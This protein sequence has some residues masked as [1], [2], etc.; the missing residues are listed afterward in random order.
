MIAGSMTV[1]GRDRF[2]VGDPVL[3]PGLQ[4]SR[5]GTFKGMRF[6]TTGTSHRW[7]VNQP[8][9]TTLR[10]MRGHNQSVIDLFEFDVGVDALRT[11]GAD[12]QHIASVS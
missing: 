9:T 11:P 4:G 1:P 7:A 5:F 8:Y 6:Y 2:R 10:V 12:I 3:R